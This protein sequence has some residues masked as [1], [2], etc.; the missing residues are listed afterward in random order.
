MGRH[1]QLF[2]SERLRL[3][4]HPL[5]RC[6]SAEDVFAVPLQR[7]GGYLMPPYR[8][9]SQGISICLIQAFA[10]AVL[11]AL[12]YAWVSGGKCFTCKLDVLNSPDA[13]PEEDSATD[14][15]RHLI[16]FVGL[17]GPCK[18]VYPGLRTLGDHKRLCLCGEFIAQTCGSPRPHDPHRDFVCARLWQGIS[19]FASQSTGWLAIHIAFGGVAAAALAAYDTMNYGLLSLRFGC[20]CLS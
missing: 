8:G 10:S 20:R 3:Q 13:W 18:L 14:I 11:P 19:G 17:L 5:T 6:T 4:V 7:L 1:E 15:D 12:T 9:F 16:M 2:H